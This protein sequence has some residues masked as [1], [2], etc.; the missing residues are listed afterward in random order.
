MYSFEVYYE[1]LTPAA[2]HRLKEAFNTSPE[3]ENWDISPIAVIEK[4]EKE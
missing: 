4:E 2:Q 3:E 1:D